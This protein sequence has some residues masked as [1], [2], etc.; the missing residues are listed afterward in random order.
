M[1]KVVLLDFE[2]KAL[3]SLRAEG[4]DAELRSTAREQGPTEPQGLPKDCEKVFFQLDRP[5][6][7]D[8]ASA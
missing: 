8:R 3:E 5:G 1:G 6:E 7:G 4:I 2:E